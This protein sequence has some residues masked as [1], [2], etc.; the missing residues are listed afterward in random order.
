MTDDMRRLRLHGLI[1]RIPQSH[2]DRVTDAGLRV[3]LFFTKVHSR[4]LRPGLSQLFD[5]CPK[6]PTRPIAAAMARLQHTLKDLFEQ[7]KLAPA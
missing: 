6:A 3:A 4:I 1:E 2:R 5:G 7:A